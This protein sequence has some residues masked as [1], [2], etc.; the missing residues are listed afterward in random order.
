MSEYFAI[1][2]SFCFAL[3]HVLNRRG[4][5]S[6]NGITASLFSLSMSAIA[7][8]ALVPFF[9]PLS[10]FRS[11]SVWFFLA[12]GIFAPGL[13]RTLTL[14]G[15]ER[16]GAARAVPIANTYPM[17]ASILAVIIMGERWTLQNFMGTSLVV[18][19]VV[20]LSKNE[21]LHVQWRKTDLIYPVMAAFAF[22]VS[23][24]LRKL[25][26]LI[27]HEPFMGAAVTAT[28][29]LLLGVVLLQAQGGRKEIALSRRSSGWFFVAGVSNTG[30]MLSVF[31]ALSFGN[32][33]TVEPLIG[34]NPVLVI[35][36]SAIFLRDLESITSRVVLGALCTVMGS[37]LVITT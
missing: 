15:M 3:A 4:L 22:A 19:G 11:P 29:G 27:L 5:A 6:S 8:W 26:L 20:I 12:G 32:I 36:L 35:L 24:N 37:I 9:V 28:T 30:A 10:T 1:Q 16:I 18:L 13:G 31:H 2:A 33:V 25:G 21:T 14:L 7:L 34:A 23:S 17:I